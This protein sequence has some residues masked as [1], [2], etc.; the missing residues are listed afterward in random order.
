M[1][2]ALFY[3]ERGVADL[4]A[5]FI[6]GKDRLGIMLYWGRAFRALRLYYQSGKCTNRR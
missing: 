6:L 2:T 3:K 1:L 4:G 5:W